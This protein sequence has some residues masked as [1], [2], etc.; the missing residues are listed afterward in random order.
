ML[1][2]VMTPSSVNEACKALL[3]AKKPMLMA[4]GTTVMPHVN[5]CDHDAETL[6]S[7]RKLA[8]EDITVSK[9]NVVT[10]GAGATIASLAKVKHLRFLS[11]AISSF[12]SPSIRNMATVGGNLFVKQ[13]YGD[14]AVCLVALGAIATIANGRTKRTEAV[15]SLA[16][17]GVKRGEI[18]TH[19]SFDLPDVGSF[20]FIK[21]ARRNLNTPSLITVAA[22][23]AP[24]VQG[25]VLHLCNVA[26]GGVVPY[27]QRV[28]SVEKL[29]LGKVFTVD[30]IEKA[31]AAVNNDIKPNTDAFA[32]AWYRARIAPVYVRRALLGG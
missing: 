29:L 24:P 4:G 17:K 7:L 3:K 16:R 22:V 27:A 19:V 14:F 6:V 8:L 26:V 9:K 30:A 32:T 15:E 23:I 1:Q 21:A 20:R 31:A 18:V 25:R 11:Q 2:L 5:A 10:I 28:K 13:P 12:A